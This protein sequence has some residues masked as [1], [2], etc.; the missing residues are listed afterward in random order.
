MAEPAKRIQANIEKVSRTLVISF[1]SQKLLIFTSRLHSLDIQS[2]S[3]LCLANKLRLLRKFR[4]QAAAILFN[5]VQ[6]DFKLPYGIP[7]ENCCNV[8]GRG[9]RYEKAHSPRS[10]R[11]LKNIADAADFFGPD[12]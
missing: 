10:R 2:I 6:G 7:L 8:R 3:N 5:A 11:T 12:G 9:R 4:T 1:P